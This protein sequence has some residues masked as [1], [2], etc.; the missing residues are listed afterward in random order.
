MEEGAP[1]PG[2]GGV[3]LKNLIEF[4]KLHPIPSNS[5]WRTRY[6]ADP[7]GGT[8]G[9]MFLRNFTQFPTAPSSNSWALDENI[10]YDLMESPGSLCRL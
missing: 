4:V 2:R 10:Q 6:G 9:L 5:H 8:E 1:E 7:L 3:P